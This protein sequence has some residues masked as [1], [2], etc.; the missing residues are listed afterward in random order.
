M[1]IKDNI[2]AT[3]LK[4]YFSASKVYLLIF[5]LKGV[6]LLGPRNFC[7]LNALYFL[8]LGG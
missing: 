5:I 3:Y 6:K 1:G 2:L 7:A 4:T 8:Y